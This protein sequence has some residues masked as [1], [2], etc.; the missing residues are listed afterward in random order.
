MVSCECSWF[1]L[2]NA[3]TLSVVSLLVAVF[4]AN[5]RRVSG[6]HFIVVDVSVL[7]WIL[8]NVVRK[9]PFL[10]VHEAHD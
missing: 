8:M 3:H 7:P 2:R 5:T 1:A 10:R 6:G 4:P 9:A